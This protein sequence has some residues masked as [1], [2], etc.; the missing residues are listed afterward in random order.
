MSYHNCAMKLLKMVPETA[1][2]A[3]FLRAEFCSPRF[4]DDLKKTMQSLNV[5]ETVITHPDITDLQQSKLRA[6][7]L[8]AYRGYQQD[9]EMFDAVPTKLT[10]YD[11]EITRQELG[12]LHYVD[13]SYWNELTRDTHLVRDGVRNI[14]QGKVVFDVPN[15]RFWALAERILNG[16]HDFEPIILWGTSGGSALEILEGHLRATAFGLAGDKAPAAI[17]VLVGLVSAGVSPGGGAGP[18]ATPR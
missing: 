7:V 10:W 13:Y 12:A 2:V 5:E 14:E 16:D 15:D 9:R 3:A 17:K 18:A 1:M 6:Q 11:A 4:S 8:G